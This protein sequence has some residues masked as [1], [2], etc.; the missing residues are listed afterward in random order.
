[1]TLRVG[2]IGL[3]HSHPFSDAQNLQELGGDIVGVVEAEREISSRFSEQFS[4]PEFSSIKELC[5]APNRPDILIVTPHPNSWHEYVAGA[6]DSGAKVFFNKVLA[7]NIEQLRYV[8]K[9]VARE[10][11]GNIST[12]SVLRFAPQLEWL[13]HQHQDVELLSIRVIAQHD[14]ALFKQRSRAWQDLPEEGGGTLMTVGIHAWE[15]IDLAVPG[16]RLQKGVG[17]TRAFPSSGTRSEDAA[18]I[19]GVLVAPHTGRSIPV[20]VLVSGVPGPDKYAIDLVHRNGIVSVELDQENTQVSLGFRGLIEH[21]ISSTSKD[22][23]LNGWCAARNVVS[24]SILAAQMARTEM[25]SRG[26]R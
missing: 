5:R 13:R 26:Y 17:W 24:N 6:I 23:V 3:A 9:L 7:A 8:E 22:Q 20:D 2:F 12:S 16:A 14:N 19:S 18:G 11:L 25:S 10:Q 1:M 15:M 4:C 21:L